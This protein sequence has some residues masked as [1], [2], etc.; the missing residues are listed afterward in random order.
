MLLFFMSPPAEQAAGGGLQDFIF[1]FGVVFLIFWLIVI[2]PQ[3]KQE[4]QR[5]EMLSQLKKGDQVVTQGGIV[6]KIVSIKDNRITLKTDENS[7]SKATFL[8]HAIIN[9]VNQK[10]T[11][12]KK[13]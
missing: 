9:I 7:N 8:R 5:K 12:E 13:S 11:T 4:Q 2:R 10:S 1:M 3:K 6:G